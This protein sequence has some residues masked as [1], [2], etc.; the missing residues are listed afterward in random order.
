MED[1][2]REHHGRPHGAQL[3]SDNDTTIRSCNLGSR[4]DFMTRDCH[5][6]DTKFVID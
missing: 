6:K 5:V 1:D 3:Y 4:N 2:R